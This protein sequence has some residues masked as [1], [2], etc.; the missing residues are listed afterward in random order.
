MWKLSSQEGG[1][2]I[3]LPLALG[4][5]KESFC[6]HGHRALLIWLHGALVTQ[7]TPVK[8]LYKELVRTD[9]PEPAGELDLST[10]RWKLLLP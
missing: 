5:G 8:H 4:S 3:Y 2:S 6:E 1:I 7:A 9:F 10:N